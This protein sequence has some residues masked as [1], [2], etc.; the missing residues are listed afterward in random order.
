MRNGDDFMAKL[1][2]VLQL[3]QKSENKNV[4]AS[5]RTYLLRKGQN[6]ENTKTTYE[7]AIRDFFKTMRNKDLEQLLPEDLIFEKHQIGAY[8]VALKEQYK[9]STVNN[10]FTAIRECY[11]RLERD[12]FSVS[13]S[14]FDVERYDE[15][16]TKPYDTL[17]HEEV[18]A[19]I[20]LVSGTRKG[21]EKA[22][23]I[24]L[25]YATAFR[26][27]S[28]LTMKWNQ[29][30]EIDGVWYAKVVGKG[31]KLSH[32]KLSDDLYNT[33]MEHKKNTK[34]DKV[35]ELTKKT[36]D[37]M[38]SYIRENMD[39]GERRIVFH[40]FKKASL[41]EVNILSG[42]DLKLIQAH[43]D[44]ADIQTTMNDYIARKKIEELLI[45][46]VNTNV[47]LEKFDEMSHEELVHLVKN[48]DRVTQ[49]R[50]LQKAGHM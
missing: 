33:L 17:T 38:M 34:G 8:Q 9:G 19:C 50:L 42:G 4:Y 44:H 48:M 39:F 49:I 43:G 22:L 15:H 21:K 31:N 12:G 16:D 46:D 35:F 41:N 25:A 27:T 11:K 1:G 5:I 24:R 32:K 36:V 40:S 28:I 37:K 47:P 7:R 23:L 6:S 3:N 20:N 10:T 26:V 29:I 18:L 45:V 13:P 30:V 14:L 2:N